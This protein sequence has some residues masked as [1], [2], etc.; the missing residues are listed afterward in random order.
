VALRAAAVHCKPSFLPISAPDDALSPRNL[1]IPGKNQTC[2][3]C[4]RKGPT[5]LGPAFCNA[6]AAVG[7]AMAIAMAST[8]ATSPLAANES[9]LPAPCTR[10]QATPRPR[11]RLQEM[12]RRPN[13]PRRGRPRPRGRDPRQSRCRPRMTSPTRALLAM[14]RLLPIRATQDI[15]TAP[16]R[17]VRARGGREEQDTVSY[18]DASNTVASRLGQTTGSWGAAV[19]DRHVRVRC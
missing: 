11:A 6:P 2:A 15:P 7:G 16:R 9:A 14:T 17:A 10:T 3:P 1:S 18:G 8:S 5:C 12:L 13:T 4:R 19:D